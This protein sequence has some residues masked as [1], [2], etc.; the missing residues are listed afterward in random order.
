HDLPPTRGYLA[1][2]HVK[3]RDE[4]G[5]LSEA[6]EVVEQAHIDEIAA[7]RA[8]LERNNLIR[9]AAS[10]QEVVIALHRYITWSPSKLL[11]VSLPDLVGQRATQN[12]PGTK[13]EYPNWRIPLA[14]AD[15]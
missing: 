5:L 12:Q 9:P 11:A 8:A 7:W 1:G 2:D 14:D 3:L 6:V 15:N 4:L 13:D 10:D